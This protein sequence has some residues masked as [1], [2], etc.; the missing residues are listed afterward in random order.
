MFDKIQR[1]IGRPLNGLETNKILVWL[2]EKK[3]TI[4]EIV[5]AYECC[6]SS[7]INYIRKYLDDTKNH[8]IQSPKWLG[9]EINE[10]PMSKKELVKII[11][12]WKIFFDNE[13]EW[14]KWGIE[15]L[16]ENGYETKEVKNGI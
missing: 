16:K 13:E 4:E 1:L 5:S 6:Q 10:E 7:N 8:K 14:K 9:K 12:D 3:Y 15:Q 2:E 11:K